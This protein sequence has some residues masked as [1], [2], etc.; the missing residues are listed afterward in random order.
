MYS[1]TGGG[2]L[3]PNAGRTGTPLYSQ[4]QQPQQ[5]QQQQQQQPQS[6]FLGQMNPQPTGYM[7]YQQT[8]F[9]SQQ[10]PMQSQFTGYPGQQPQLQ[11][12]QQPPQLQQ[13]FTGYPGQQ[14]QQPLQQQY[15]GFPG[16]ISGGFGSGTPSVPAIPP[17]P[18][19]PQ[20][21]QQQQQQQQQPTP[22]PPAPTA[23]S[24][25]GNTIKIPNVRLSFIT[26]EDQVKFEQLFK[27]AVGNG[28]ALTGDRARG[29][30]MKSGLS[31][32]DLHQI[33]QLAN[34]TKSGALLF[35]E[36]VLAMYL[37]NV[38]K[39]GRALPQTLPDLIKNEVS[40]MVDIIS[41][42]IPDAAPPA[43]PKSNVPNFEVTPSRQDSSTPTQKQ[44]SNSTLLG[45]LVMQ[46]TG[47]QQPQPTGYQQPQP[48]GYQQPQPTGYQMQQPT[49]F[50]SIVSQPTGYQGGLMSQPTGY[51]QGPGI[52]NVPPV[53][54]MPTGM[55]S[56]STLSSL[57]AGSSFLQSQPTG[58]PGQWGYINASSTDL[59]G[60]EALQ[61]QMMPQPGREGGWNMQGLTG[62]APIPW[63]VTKIEKQ[64]YDKI[65]DGWDGLRK[66]FI[67]GD[68]AIEVFGQS[69]L[70]KEELMRIWTLADPAN[71][72][73]LD[74]D[75]FAVAMHLIYRKLN[76]HDIPSRL[77]PEL[78]PPSTK[79]LA[80]SVNTVKGF[81][82][83]GRENPAGGGVSYM[84][85][86]SFHGD[87]NQGLR[88][89]GTVY[90][91]NDD[92]SSGYKSSAR[93]RA[94]GV[95]P[96]PAI[97]VSPSPGPEEMSLD[98][99]RKKV[100][101]KRILLDAID[102]KDEARLEDED[103]LDRR[104]RRDADDLYRRIRRIQEDIDSHPNAGLRSTNSDAERRQMK[105]QLQNL[106]DRLPDIASK[107]RNT[108]RRIADAKLELFRLR[109]AR[110][111][112]ESASSIVGT[113][114]GGAITE[115]DRLK[116]KS[117]AMMQQRLAVLTGKPIEPTGEDGAEAASKRLADESQKVNSEKANNE[118][119]T[120]DV[121]DSVNEFRRTLED[122]LN[123]VDGRSNDNTSEHERR[124]WE[125]GLG[126]EDEVRDFIFDLQRQSRSAALRREDDRRRGDRL[127]QDRRPA[128]TRPY[129]EERAVSSPPPRSATAVP[130]PAAAPASGLYSSF[131]SAEE[132]AAYI[133]QQAEQKMAERLAALGIKHPMTVNLG[134]TPQQR[135]ER[136]QREREERIRKAD[137]E[138]AQRERLR[139]ARLQ[140]DM[141]APP[142]TASPKK[143][144]KAPPPPPSR[145]NEFQDRAKAE[146]ER[147]RA[148]EAELQ[149]EQ[150]AKA[151]ERQALEEQASNEEEEL[152]REE[153]AAQARLRALE[154]E[155]RQGKLRKKEEAA[156]KKAAFQ[157]QKQK[158]AQLAERRAKIEAAR[159]EEER[160]MQMKKELEEDSSS[161]EEGPEAVGGQETPTQESVGAEQFSMPTSSPPAPPPAPPM[162]GAMPQSPPSELPMASPPPAPPLPPSVA[163]TQTLQESKNP[164]F[165]KDFGQPMGL[166]GGDTSTNA[167]STSGSNNPFFNLTK[168]QPEQKSAA[169]MPDIH[170]FNPKKQDD[171]DWSVVDDDDS[172]SDDGEMPS[173]NTTA[174]LAA[175]LFATM[176]P[177]RPLSSMDKESQPPAPPPP[178]PPPP[179]PSMGGPGGPP[180]PPPLPPS[181]SAPPLPMVTPDRGSLL[182]QIG[183]G[184]RLRKATTVDKSGAATAGRVL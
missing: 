84:K 61:R 134:E 90:K 36:F 19:I 153:E 10:Q 176:A 146:A 44:V 119:M 82:A 177:P 87:N 25:S 2:F 46:P 8:G 116:A 89:D 131:N 98:Q 28:Q 156:K 23:T 139:Q 9:P 53:P 171:D 42:N 51:G 155:M 102:I 26:L 14:S 1:Q 5:Q 109:D 69:G 72:G 35:P 133:K 97:S 173:R 175:S 78:I 148:E 172:D 3:N 113:G 88:K 38:K 49:G 65:F 91:F 147:K 150:E 183:Q 120:R 104:D 130:T 166:N 136:E 48:T 151:A 24:L 43:P 123:D 165:K 103:T 86:R 52:G 163:P 16:P 110:E 34:T 50:Q 13:Q 157:A 112:P 79:K 114:P 128:S 141:P 70:P 20:V 62:N 67:G 40:G 45:S 117:R 115:S 37:C 108:E 94:R 99:L 41:F 106:T 143:G 80:D 152:A 76:G 95:S 111:H 145:K 54:P 93:H 27:A 121:E 107:V 137:E 132:R 33:W 83:K 162:P 66:G 154:E 39:Q 74:K 7:G 85:S 178:P 32:T 22:P 159:R 174:Q 182:S 160:L 29:I 105:R 55:S 149:R 60:L 138:E 58:R 164:F 124:R 68:V 81:L 142:P 158:E 184:V 140:G 77:P 64:M 135:A 144:P 75:E 12:Q 57:S 71:K 167:A 129:G 17:I 96:S 126:V 18:Q 181:G 73:K 4:Q 125:D 122:S 127:E 11:Q 21:F 161:D 59:P 63:A 31:A 100:K 179:M 6:G 170:I 15:T 47:Y 118:R 92:A 180:P 169:P 101:E 56:V 30:L 168:D